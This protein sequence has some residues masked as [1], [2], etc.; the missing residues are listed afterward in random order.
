MNPG[1]T[2]RP[3]WDSSTGC[4]YIPWLVFTLGLEPST[5]RFKRHRVIHLCLLRQSR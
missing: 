1:L 4:T 3:I 5:I 2:V